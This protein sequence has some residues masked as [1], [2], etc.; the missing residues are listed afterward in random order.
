MPPFPSSC[1]PQVFLQLSIEDMLSAVSLLSRE[2]GLRPSQVQHMLLDEP[3]LLHLAAPGN[4]ERC[5]AA[6][7]AV[8]AALPNAKAL[9][10]LLMRRP[11]LLL[12]DGTQLAQQLEALERL[13]HSSKRNKCSSQDGLT[14]PANG[15]RS[16]SSSGDSTGASSSSSGG[17]GGESG[18]GGSSGGGGGGSSSGGICSNGDRNGTSDS[19]NSVQPGSCRDTVPP[20]QCTAADR[21]AG[22]P[23]TRV[24]MKVVAEAVA[25]QPLL[26]DMV[27]GDASA[28]AAAAVVRAL[29]ET[30]LAPPNRLLLLLEKWPRLLGADA[31]VGVQECLPAV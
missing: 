15:L 12:G 23:A 26:L 20:L 7:A 30:G 28:E 29:A 19:S 22:R 5:R 27:Q 25:R 17:G 4:V 31:Q 2:L 24:D 21:G 16:S 10:E 9:G 14:S 1:N 13:L 11:G 8:N 18:S 3:L 6:L